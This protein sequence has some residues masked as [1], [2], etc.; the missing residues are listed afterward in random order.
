MCLRASRRIRAEKRRKAG[1]GYRAKGREKRERVSPESMTTLALVLALA[2]A[3]AWRGVE[4]AC[5]VPA[6]VAAVQLRL[7]GCTTLTALLGYLL[8]AHN[9]L[10]S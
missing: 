6:A 2:S 1:I 7:Y 4:P 5:L 9:Q 3:L 10:T 8:R